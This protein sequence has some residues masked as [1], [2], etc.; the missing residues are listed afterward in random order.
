MTGILIDF[1]VEL[2]ETERALDVR[3]YS[4]PY[5][6]GNAWGET[7]LVSSADLQLVIA[8]ADS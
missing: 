6:T 5:E 3:P 8:W 1:Y 7:A 2:E 4:L